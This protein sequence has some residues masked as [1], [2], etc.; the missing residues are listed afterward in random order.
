M[1]DIA[2]RA[3]GLLKGC[4]RTM[5]LFEIAFRLFAMYAV[6]PACKGLFNG[7]LRITGLHYLTA[8]NLI[9][10]L[11]NPLMLICFAAIFLAFSLSS[12]L[13]IS[14]L[15]T[16]LDASSGPDRALDVFQMIHEGAR[17]TLRLEMG[18]CLYG[19]D[20]PGARW[21]RRSRASPTC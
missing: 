7:T 19:N 3:F 1:R 20:C 18:Y 17:D 9:P 10:A 8:D 4:W 2:N 5:V 11:T 13:E 15:I 6:F 16:C 12:M 14:C 21:A